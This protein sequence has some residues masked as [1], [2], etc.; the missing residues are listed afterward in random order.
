M[1]NRFLAAIAGA[2]AFL[3]ILIAQLNPS[4]PRVTFACV[5]LAL[6]IFACSRVSEEHRRERVRARID[7]LKERVATS[8]SLSERDQIEAGLRELRGGG[9]TR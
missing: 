1:A 5:A 3:W 4:A 8:A 7:S 6:F 9:G 2:L